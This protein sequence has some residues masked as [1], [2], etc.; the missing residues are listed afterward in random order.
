MKQ[1]K[2]TIANKLLETL[3]DNGGLSKKEQW[4]LYKLRLALRPRID[5]QRE[6]EDIIRSKYQE[7]ADEKGEL[8]G[9]KADDFV[10]EMKSIG[11]LD[12]EIEGLTKPQIKMT[13]GITF[14]IIEPLEEFVEFLPPEE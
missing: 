5:F 10:K 14:K 2:I 1:S 13:D 4:E 9:K 3:A 7:F 8:V 6:Q 12:V 11:D